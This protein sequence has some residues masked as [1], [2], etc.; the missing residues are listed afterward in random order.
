[1]LIQSARLNLRSSQAQ[2]S[3]RI[4]MSL[5]YQVCGLIGLVVAD[6]ESQ[7][8]P[9]EKLSISYF[10]ASNELTLMLIQSARLNL[11]SFQAQESL[12]IPMS[13]PCQVCGLIG[14]VVADLEFQIRPY[15]KLNPSVI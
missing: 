1:M 11:R 7:I 5:P 4:P 13:L 15:E 10:L 12:R 8:R 3:L 2:E 9:Y 14:L 6:L